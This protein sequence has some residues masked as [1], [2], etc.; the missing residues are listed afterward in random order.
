MIYMRPIHNLSDT[1]VRYIAELTT[2][3]NDGEFIRGIANSSVEFRGLT[4]MI[5]VGRLCDVLGKAMCLCFR[6]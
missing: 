3:M 1:Q 5:F 6:Y 2:I 4:M